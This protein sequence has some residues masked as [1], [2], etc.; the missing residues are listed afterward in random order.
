MSAAAPL[1]RLKAGLDWHTT[2][3]TTRAIDARFGSQLPS[4]TTQHDTVAANATDDRA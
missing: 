1:A 3:P 2:E 4:A